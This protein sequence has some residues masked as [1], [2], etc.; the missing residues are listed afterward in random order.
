MDTYT[1]QT[2]TVPLAK[3]GFIV[4]IERDYNKKTVGARRIAKL[5]LS[6][7]VG[8][9]EAYDRMINKHCGVPYVHNLRWFT[10]VVD[11]ANP[12]ETKWHYLWQEGR[13]RA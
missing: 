9:E 10:L 8:R 11:Q 6:G 2:T 5:K 1:N 13:S 3:F 12:T 7:T 4:G